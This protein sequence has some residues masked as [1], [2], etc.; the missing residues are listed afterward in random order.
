M[1]SFFRTCQQT[2][3]WN[4]KPDLR[5][6]RESPGSPSG[7]LSFPGR[8]AHPSPLRA[9]GCFNLD[10]VKQKV[11]FKGCAKLLR[12]TCARFAPTDRTIARFSRQLRAAWI[13]S[14]TCHWLSERALLCV[15]GA[16]RCRCPI[17]PTDR[18]NDSAPTEN[19]RENE[20]G[21]GEGEERRS[22]VIHAACGVPQ[23]NPS[24][25]A[26]AGFTDNVT[27]CCFDVCFSL[28]SCRTAISRGAVSYG[29]HD[30]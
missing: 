7:P 20:A 17:G 30:V 3:Q 12:S 10:F 29:T 24:F 27:S 13:F 9:I 21:R 6:R 1:A 2:L 22:H 16:R 11:F 28:A 18:R 23:S 4:N 19:S 8:Q 5:R 25:T 26:V 15:A 14:V